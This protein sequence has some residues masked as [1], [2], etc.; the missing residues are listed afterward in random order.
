MIEF[1]ALLAKRLRRSLLRGVLSDGARSRLRNGFAASLIAIWL[2]PIPAHAQAYQCRMPQNV[3]VPTVN[4]DKPERRM[5]IT[6]Y[7]MALSWSPEFCKPREGQRAHVTQCS[8]KNGRFGLVVHGLW[9]N[10]RGNKWPQYCRTPYALSAPE[11]RRNMCMMPSARLIAHQWLKHGSCMGKPP[12]T[13]FKV[14]RILWDGLRI[15]DYDRLSRKD[16]LTA[17][18]IRGALADAN[19][20]WEREHIG[21]K[22][23]S[24]GWL[25]EIRLCYTKRFRSTPC[26]S[27]RFGAA[28]G[29]RAKIWRGM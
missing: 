5:P 13:Y 24:R 28:D 10:G 6:G 18:D 14:T 16:G 17:G 3:S 4:S 15:P 25:Q 2:A 8:G 27:N 21:V 29:D 12:A 26:D 9:P 20:G 7:T 11:L 23:N 19:D 1:F 22:L